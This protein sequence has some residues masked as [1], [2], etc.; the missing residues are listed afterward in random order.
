MKAGP[1]ETLQLQQP[2]IM[3]EQAIKN[4]TPTMMWPIAHPS[5]RPSLSLPGS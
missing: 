4:K 5:R 3:I 1:T 2:K